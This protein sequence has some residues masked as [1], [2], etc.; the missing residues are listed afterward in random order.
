[1]ADPHSGDAYEDVE[2]SLTLSPVQQLVS[3]LQPDQRRV[4]ELLRHPR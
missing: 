3:R 4:I 1:M 2:R